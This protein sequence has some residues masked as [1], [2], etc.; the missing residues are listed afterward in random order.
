MPDEG[1]R[2]SGE[3]LRK[4]GG[5]G[6]QRNQAMRQRSPLR[7][8]GKSGSMGKK[9]GSRARKSAW[10]GS[11]EKKKGQLCP[12]PLSSLELCPPPVPPP[13]LP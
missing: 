13:P 10:H 3:D 6:G 9:L 12:R 7:E 4:P 11:A 8:H 2:K 1:L 5:G